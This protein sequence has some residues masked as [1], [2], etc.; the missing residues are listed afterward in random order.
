MRT[1][2]FQ[3]QAGGWS[4]ALL[5]AV[6]L[7]GCG[8]GEDDAPAREFADVTGKVTYNGEPLKSGK[9]MFQP[10]TGAV[11]VGDIQPD[12]T[13]AMKAVIGQ[14]VVTIESREGQTGEMS[15]DRPESRQQPKSNIP[16]KYST[17]ASGLSF[18]VQEGS[19]TAN[20]DLQ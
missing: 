20:F 3:R 6:A 11:V 18:S 19:N 9:V 15:A 12:G 2:S 14:N 1:V 8:G 5:L 4:T 16:D 7:I 13:Y 17:P 10:P